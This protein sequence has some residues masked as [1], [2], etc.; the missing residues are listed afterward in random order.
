MNKDFE[1]WSTEAPYDAPVFHYGG[2]LVLPMMISHARQRLFGRLRMRRESF[3]R[4]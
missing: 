1:V 4:P 3:R 2:T